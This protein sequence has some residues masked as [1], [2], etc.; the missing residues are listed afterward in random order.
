MAGLFIP[1]ALFNPL[2]RFKLGTALA[3]PSLGALLGL[4]A[5]ASC[6]WSIW[7]ALRFA[8]WLP[9]PIE[10]FIPPIIGGIIPSGGIPPRPWRPIGNIFICRGFV[11]PGYTKIV[12]CF[13]VSFPAF[14]ESECLDLTLT[15]LSTACFSCFLS[16]FCFL[17]LSLQDSPSLDCSVSFCSCFLSRFFLAPLPPAETISKFDSVANWSFEWS[18]VTVAVFEAFSFFY[19]F[20]GV[21]V[22]VESFGNCA[23][24]GTGFAAL[25]LESRG[26]LKLLLF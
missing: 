12:F 14:S 10:W 26:C 23:K 11:W 13:L 17:L 20:K 15:F 18:P 16:F 5:V 1:T 7:C 21:F 25:A 9:N 4:L 3:L 24:R 22:E 8:R 6:I 19:F 2:R